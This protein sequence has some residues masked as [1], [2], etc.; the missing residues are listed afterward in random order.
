MSKKTPVAAIRLQEMTQ[1]PQV[2][3]FLRYIQGPLE[4]QFNSATEPGLAGADDLT[5]AGTPELLEKAKNAR[6]IVVLDK[7]LMKNPSFSP[8]QVI[9]STPNISAALSICLPLFDTKIQRFGEGIHPQAQ[10][11]PS[12][13]IGKSVTISAFAV[14]G[15]NAEIGDHCKIGPHAV[16]EMNAKVGAH[17]ILHAH[18]FIGADCELG[19]HCEIHPHTCVGSDGFGFVQSPDGKRHKIP[20][21][22]KVVL[23][24]HV[25]L[26]AS[27]TIDRATMSETRIGEGSKFDNLCHIAH[28]CRIGKNNVFAAGFMMAGSSEIGDNCTF[29]GQCVVADLVKIASGCHFGG[30]SGIHNDVLTPGVY[31][32]YPLQP[33]KDNMRTTANLVHLTEMRKQLAQIQKH[34]KLSE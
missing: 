3:A 31:S 2:S 1:N 8:D 20:Q 5:F 17:S 34:L 16:V 27:C 32:G 24:N 21:I 19:L 11:H 29:G 23:E 30:W 9:F 22:G 28:N 18:S 7:L 14:I 12:A 10:I 13:R 4:A 26:G 15:F 25:E 6:G 33:F